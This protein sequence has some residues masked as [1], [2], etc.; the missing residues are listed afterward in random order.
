MNA[1]VIIPAA[2]VGSRFGTSIPKQY[3][4]LCNKPVL[5]HTIDI[6]TANPRIA[7]MII[8]VS[9]E[10]TLAEQLIHLPPHGQL[11]HKGGQSRAETVANGLQY[12]LDTHTID[13]KDAI[14]VHDAARCCLPQNALNRLLDH[15]HHPN[16]ALLAVPVT[17]TLKRQ[18]QHCE[19]IETV[20]RTDLWQA[21]TPQMFPAYLLHQAL[22]HTD[23]HTITD[24]ASAIET[25]G[26]KPLLVTGDN[27]NIKLT[28]P[29]DAILAALLLQH[30][31]KE[32]P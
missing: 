30:H 24:E 1:T 15:I 12:L 23:W 21:Q 16:G 28:H 19:A 11:I 27:C 32:H 22:K 25:L 20:S 8:V 9:S 29:D 5:Q 7:R 13:T 26:I 14:L 4:K 18:N 10:D 3:I 6:F 31:A 17:D 2:G